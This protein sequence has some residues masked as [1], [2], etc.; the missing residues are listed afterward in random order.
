MTFEEIEKLADK[1]EK[2]WRDLE[3]NDPEEYRRRV[4]AMQPTI[5]RYNSEIGIGDDDTSD[6]DDD[7][8]D[9]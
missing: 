3:Q 2:E 8:D 9:E 7:D 5:D 4:A 6:D 1:V